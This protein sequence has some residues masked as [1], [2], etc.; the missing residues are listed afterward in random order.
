MPP[1]HFTLFPLI[2]ILV[3]GSVC[4]C[5]G[6]LVL[7]QLGTNEWKLHDTTLKARLAP[8][9]SSLSSDVITPSQAAADFSTLLADFLGGIDAF[10]G[11]EGRGGRGS[12]GNL[13]I[14][15]EAYFRAKLEKKRLRRLVFGR[16]RRVDQGLRA[17]FYQAVRAVSFIRNER[18][19]RQRERDKKGQEKSFLKDFWSFSKRAV[20]GMIGKDIERPSFDK[21]FADEWYKSRYST[22]VPLAQE[23]VSWFPRL[24]EVGEEFD[25]GPIRP[26]D[27]KTVLSKKKAS[28]SPGD[29]GIL[30]GHLKN[31]ESTHH[32]LATL[33]TKTLLTSPTP[34]EGWGASS[35]VLIHKAGDTGDPSNFRPIAL[36]S[37]VGKLFHQILSERISKYLVSNGFLD[38]ETQKAFLSK[39]SG[40][41]DHNLVM[42]EII[43]HAKFHHRTVHVTWFD[44]EDAFGSVSHD[45][46]PI[47]LD[48][49]KIPVNVRDY[50]VS[51][52]GN[53]KGKIRTSDWISE[54]FRFR[55]GVFQ[56]D[57]LSP[58]IFL[59]CFNPIIEEL[60]KYEASDGY[61]L[62]GMNFITLPFADDFNL[63]TR[64]IRKHR[65]LMA[66]LHELTSSMGLKLKPR[67]CRS[68]SV[69]AGKSQEENF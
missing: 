60:K 66:R 15:D 5:D 35:I 26:R 17:Q 62:D 39:I 18:E 10:V 45:L 46:I 19:R 68:L 13:D 2:P 38:S 11:G 29:D 30:N 9:H 14:S 34:W 22:P 65:K 48:R 3:L 53:L 41:E 49:M 6:R 51:L 20:N 52:Y 8:L 57:P 69:K 32:F 27:V 16:G 56:G 40:C 63:I 55:K 12:V 54:E 33:F 42:G 59:I 36:T 43:N 37:C 47:C 28:S 50:I 25:M 61:N 24:P 21:A 31:L 23:A 64:D 7:P 1:F 67:K 4:Q 58:I 44:L